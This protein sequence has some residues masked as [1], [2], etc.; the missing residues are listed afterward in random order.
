MSKMKKIVSNSLE[1]SVKQNIVD[2]SFK[3]SQ[4][5]IA[6]DSVLQI[7]KSDLVYSYSYPQTD[8]DEPYIGET[9]GRFKEKIIDHNKRYKKSNIYKHC[10]E[11]VDRNYSNPI[12]NILEAFLI[13]ELKPLLKKQD[14]SFLLNCL[15]DIN[16]YMYI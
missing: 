9:E 5:L 12:K 1:Y 13:K 14:K 7:Y 2:N 15:I 4:Y 8:Y 16:I 10:S 11:K 6:K 3:L